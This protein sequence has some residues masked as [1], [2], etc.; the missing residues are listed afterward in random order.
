VL[1]ALF[2][3]EVVEFILNV[4]TGISRRRKKLTMHAK[5]P[6]QDSFVVVVIFAGI[7]MI[8]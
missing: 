1:H 3:N 7:V 5:N 4:P 8:P 6:E 2:L